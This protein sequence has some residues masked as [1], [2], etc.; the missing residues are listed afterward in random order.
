MA[1]P[2]IADQVDHDVFLEFLAVSERELGDEDR[3]FRIVAV[4]VEDR[5]FDHLCDIGT[6]VCRTGVRGPAGREANLVVDDDVH[7]TASAETVRLR[8][9][10]GFGDD[11]LARK[12]RIPVN[13]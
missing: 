1:V 2:P 9:L 4:H 3:G 8:H 7:G 10:E 13:Q 5:C 12:S 6:V 11:A